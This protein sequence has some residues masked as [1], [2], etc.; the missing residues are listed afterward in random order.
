MS[1][2]AIARTTDQCELGEGARWHDR[3]AE[4]LRVDILAGRVF[5]DSQ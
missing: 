1:G 2:K 4:L 5:R 3:R